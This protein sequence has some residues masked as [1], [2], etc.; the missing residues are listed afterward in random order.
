MSGS[1]I[2]KKPLFWLS[3]TVV[4]LWLVI[5]SWP[6]KRLHLIFCD[7]GQGDA[8]LITYGQTQILIDGGPDNKVLSCLSEYLPFWDRQ[9]EAVFLT[10]PDTD[11]L[12]GLLTVFQRYQ[13]KYFFSNFKIEGIMKAKSLQKGDK[14]KIGLLQFLTLWPDSKE[15]PSKDINE[16]SLVLEMVF[17]KFKVFLPGDITQK[18][19]EKIDINSVDI[20]KVA[21]HGS[22]N[23][24]GEN[25]LDKIKPQLAVISVGENRFGHP[26]EETLER[27][28]KSQIK[29]LRTDEQQ[30]I[31]IV[32]D[33]LEWYNH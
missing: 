14:V 25:L 26:A 10:H 30:D 16:N 5:F 3:L 17:G 15:I 33:G 24:T 4:L 29:V 13:V 12:N 21:H 19:E 9:L 2:L 8:V 1:S 11:H 20:L 31:E 23:S 22:K 6:D 32:S 7:V 27:L 18:I 28:L